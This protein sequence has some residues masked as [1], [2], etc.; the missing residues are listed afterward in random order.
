MYNHNGENAIAAADTT[1]LLHMY[2]FAL[3][4]V[5]VRA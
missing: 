3:L 2:V 4:R 1:G 5:C